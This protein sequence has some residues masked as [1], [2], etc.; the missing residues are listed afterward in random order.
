MSD[1]GP[2]LDQVAQKALEWV[3]SGQ[4]IGLGTGRAA[5]QF[6]RALGARVKD[7]LD[8]RGVPTSKA[9]EALAAELGIPLLSL[10]EAGSL[11]VTFDGADEFTAGLDLVKGWGGALV[12]E[13]IVAAS[14]RCLVILVG[15]EKFVEKLGER[16]K[17]PVE[18][19]PFGRAL[20]ERRLGEMGCSPELRQ[21]DS[22]PY[23][24]DN[25][26]FILDCAV[27]RIEDPQALERDLSSIPGL[28]G[29]GLFLGMADAV[30]CQRDADVEVFS[31]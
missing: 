13:K 11:D 17:L 18:I 7:G 10:A 31:K 4:T 2:T 27:G 16:G 12:R 22:G 14:S 24:T 3:E 26:N 29:T 20:C 23:L 1:P 9:T 30:L 21:G 5:E 19:V 8:V 25:G 6:V 15:S 28:V